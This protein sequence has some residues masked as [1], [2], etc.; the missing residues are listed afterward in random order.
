MKKKQAIIF[1]YSNGNLY[2]KIECKPGYEVDCNNSEYKS[3]M[4]N[5]KI[6]YIDNITLYNNTILLSNHDTAIIEY[7]EVE[8]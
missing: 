5:S 7:R 3:G 1:L 2:L 6:N 8:E 4:T